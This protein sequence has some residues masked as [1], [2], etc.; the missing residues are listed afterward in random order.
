[1][2]Q[3]FACKKSTS[4]QGGVEKHFERTLNAAPVEVLWITYQIRGHFWG[5]ETNY[6][7]NQEAGGNSK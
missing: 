3:A 1:M 2:H 7:V 4:E 6:L 5:A